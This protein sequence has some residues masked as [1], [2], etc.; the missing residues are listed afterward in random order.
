MSEIKKRDNSGLK[1]DI[2]SASAEL[3]NRCNQLVADFEERQR[4]LQQ[5]QA[6]VEN[7]TA[8]D[9][10]SVQTRIRQLLNDRGLASAAARAGRTIIGLNVATNKTQSIPTNIQAT[11]VKSQSLENL[12]KNVIEDIER[13]MIEVLSS[14]FEKSKHF[15]MAQA[16]IELNLLSHLNQSIAKQSSQI[17]EDPVLIDALREYLSEVKSILSDIKDTECKRLCVFAKHTKFLAGQL[18]AI[19]GRSACSKEHLQNIIKQLNNN[20]CNIDQLGKDLIN[21]FT[22]I[23]KELEQCS[24]TENISVI[25]ELLN[26]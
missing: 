25:D 26:N 10:R 23:T 6:D 19:G 3:S 11:A 13:R 17:P 4:Q 5:L 16:R 7:K 20:K 9:V 18:T 24:P 15:E 8:I 22:L 21:F 1:Q 2:A 12:L 14:R